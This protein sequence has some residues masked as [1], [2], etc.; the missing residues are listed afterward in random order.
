MYKPADGS[1][2]YTPA[3]ES[4]DSAQHGENHRRRQPEA[5]AGTR[6]SHYQSDQYVCMYVCI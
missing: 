6:K 2:V 5:S 3:N 1:S 4:A